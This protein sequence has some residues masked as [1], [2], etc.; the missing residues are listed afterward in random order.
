MMPSI[1]SLRFDVANWQ[2][3]QRSE[4]RIVWFN[5]VPDILILEFSPHPVH[6]PADL[7]NMTRIRVLIEQMVNQ[8]AGALI[9]AEHLLCDEIEAAKS[10]FKYRQTASSRRSPQGIVYAGLYIFPFADFHY[11]LKAQCSEYGTTG[12]R[13]AAVVTQQPYTG[14]TGSTNVNAM[15][16]MRPTPT[17]QKVM[18]GLSDD[19]KY[20][21]SFPQ[22]PLS[23]LRDYLKQIE[24][25]LRADENLK[26]A[27]PFRYRS[28]QQ[29][30]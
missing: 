3:K 6:L 25:T 4:Q 9:S 21:I 27:E 1:A 24:E 30:Q 10:I 16:E 12:L 26:L 22:H 17:G 23:R 11:L 19:E 14:T 5:Q 8:N 7:Q 29:S 15:E 18:T 2:M 13:E 28:S 20:D